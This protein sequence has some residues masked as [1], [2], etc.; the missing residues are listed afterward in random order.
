M[1][2]YDSSNAI[3]RQN[4]RTSQADEG[5]T[6]ACVVIETSSNCPVDCR[7]AVVQV[8]GSDSAAFVT[9]QSSCSS[10]LRLLT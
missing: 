1:C 9:E 8:G 4:A 5:P 3:A 2:V 10:L 6:T 7:R